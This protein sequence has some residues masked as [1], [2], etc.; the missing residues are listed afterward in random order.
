MGQAALPVMIMMT[1]ASTVVSV[2]QSRSQQ[3]LLNQQ[4]EE[5]RESLAF[6]ME[7][8]TNQIKSEGKEQEI[9]RLRNL[10]AVIGQNI[11]SSIASGLTIEGTPSNIIESNIEA[12]REDIEIIQG[13]VAAS[14]AGTV[15]GGA[16]QAQ[17]IE[18]GRRVGVNAAGNQATSAIIGGIAQGAGYANQ[19]YMASKGGSL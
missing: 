4:A 13:N 11:T 2:S 15:A 18:S 1:A 8:R 19:S 12:A 10:R 3:A 6:Q 16:A 5:S 9:D 14:I 7:Q 17:A